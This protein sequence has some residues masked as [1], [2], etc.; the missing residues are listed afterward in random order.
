MLQGAAAAQPWPVHQVCGDVQCGLGQEPEPHGVNQQPGDLQGT[1]TA[2][3]AGAGCAAAG[4]ACVAEG[5]RPWCLR[6]CKVGGGGILLW[7]AMPLYVCTSSV[8]PFYLLT[9]PTDTLRCLSRP[10]NLPFSIASSSNT[11][12]AAGRDCHLVLVSHL[13]QSCKRS[14]N[15][16]SALCLQHMPAC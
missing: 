12:T 7:H 9:H 16:R 10:C 1:G 3:A 11:H 8:Y 4:G 5:F 14:N 13:V 2:R 15:C 6:Y